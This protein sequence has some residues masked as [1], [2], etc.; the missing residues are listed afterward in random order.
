MREGLN[1]VAAPEPPAHVGTCVD[2]SGDFDVIA[3]AQCGFR[4]VLPLP[5]ADELAHAY[6]HDYYAVE[7]PLYLEGTRRDLD[8]WRLVHGDRLAALEAELP[9]AR[10]R[11][12]EIGSGP[13]FFLLHARERGWRPLGV[14]PSHQAA[15]HTRSL[16]LD[17]V[18]A[19][20]DAGSAAALGTF[21]VVQ[22][23]NVLE[24]VPDPLEVLHLAHQRLA[25]GGLVSVIVPN[26]YN[27]FQR[28]ARDA[29]DH[30][31]WWVAPP[32]HLNFFDFDSLAATLVR[33]GF[34]PLTRSGSFPIDLFLLMGE[35]YVGDD[36]TGRRC[37]E[38]RMR[39]EQ[40]LERAGQGEL[41]RALYRNLAAL[42]LGREAWIVARRP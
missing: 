19:F 33:A 40:S 29:C 9:P 1:R 10:R 25:P 8:W 15:A 18:E 37:H 22:M 11:L 28:A 34:E 39:F 27:P 23:T 12:L 31:P 35:R 2:R 3:C 42:G 38:M 7:K 6:R 30:A 41:R 20:F 4:H 17:V 14:E 5:S 26:D 36:A 21:D 32:H 16:G 24:H 13:G